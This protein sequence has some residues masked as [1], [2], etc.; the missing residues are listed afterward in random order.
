MEGKCS[1][2]SRDYKGEVSGTEFKS[3]NGLIGKTS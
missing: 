2:E 3:F 1:W